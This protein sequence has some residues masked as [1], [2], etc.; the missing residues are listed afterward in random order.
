M[1]S[2]PVKWY[3]TLTSILAD[4]E[5]KVLIRCQL[6]VELLN[7]VINELLHLLY[8][9]YWQCERHIKT[10]WQ[11]QTTASCDI[12][13][14]T[15]CRA[16]CQA[17]GIRTTVNNAD[18]REFTLTGKQ[19]TCK[20]IPVGTS[21]V[22]IQYTSLY[23]SRIQATFRWSDASILPS[24][25]QLNGCLASGNTQIAV[26]QLACLKYAII[27]PLIYAHVSW[28]RNNDWNGYCVWTTQCQLGN[29]PSILVR[30]VGEGKFHLLLL[31]KYWSD[32]KLIP[33]SHVSILVCT[34]VPIE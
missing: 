22:L 14:T 23:L 30:V 9:P 19:V 3:C 24:S 10:F 16:G 11:L 4:A 21:G 25:R 27:N 20:L 5:G 34:L 17:Q 29:H 15:Y 1:T 13:L 2:G 28:N 12:I 8:Y 32:V 6:K 18:T 26:M 33:L 31:L 7:I